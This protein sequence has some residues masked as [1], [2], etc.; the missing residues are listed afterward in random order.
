MVKIIPEGFITIYMFP[1]A[2]K[3]QAGQRMLTDIAH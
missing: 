3:K 1:T 2:V